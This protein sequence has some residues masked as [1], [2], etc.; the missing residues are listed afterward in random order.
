MVDHA[1]HIQGPRMPGM[2][3]FGLLIH[4]EVLALFKLRLKYF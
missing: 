4:C 1:P 2:I 3:S